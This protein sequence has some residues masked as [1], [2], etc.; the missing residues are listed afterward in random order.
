MTTMTH[1]YHITTAK[2]LLKYKNW[3]LTIILIIQL[4]IP[5]L[6]DNKFICKNIHQSVLQ[7]TSTFNPVDA[8]TYF[9]RS[10]YSC[11]VKASHK[12]NLFWKVTCLKDHSFFV[13]KVTSW[14]RFDCSSNYWVNI[15]N[16]SIFVLRHF[17][18]CSYFQVNTMNMWYINTLLYFTL[19]TLDV[20]RS[21]KGDYDNIKTI[22]C[23]N[24]LE[25]CLRYYQNP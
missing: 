9:K 21:L 18:W 7:H 25:I 22:G 11:P 24:I 19:K 2:Y 13:L 4:N 8:V 20:R 23:P 6:N 5:P 12:S 15:F 10:H 16:L 3:E 17:F 14:C 1:S